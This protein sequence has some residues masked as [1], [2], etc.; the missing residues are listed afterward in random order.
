ML[1]L[2]SAGRSAMNLA[3]HWQKMYMFRLV[4]HKLRWRKKEKERESSRHVATKYD[5]SIFSAVMDQG[6]GL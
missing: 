1:P 3:P 2:S 4:L 6:A 5:K